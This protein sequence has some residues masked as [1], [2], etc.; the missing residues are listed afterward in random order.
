M[1]PAPSANGKNTSGDSELTSPSALP[2]VRKSANSPRLFGARSHRACHS[3]RKVSAYH[4]ST[5][6]CQQCQQQ[7][8]ARAA[9][10]AYRP[11]RSPLRLGSGDVRGS[12]ALHGSRADHLSASAGRN[13]RCV[14]GALLSVEEERRHSRYHSRASA[15]PPQPSSSWERRRACFLNR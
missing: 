6:P 8:Y 7:R 11:A 10:A 4:D 3:K 13:M 9:V 14:T 15:P 12:S 1:L 5:T 2:P